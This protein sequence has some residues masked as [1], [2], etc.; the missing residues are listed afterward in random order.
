M[1][2]GELI[3]LVDDIAQ[4][5]KRAG[6]LRHAHG[7]ALVEEMH[8]LAQLDVE[9]GLTVAQRFYR[10]LHALDIAAVIGAPHIDQIAEPAAEL[11][12]VIGDVAGEIGPRPIRFFQRAIDFVAELRRAEQGLRPRLPVVRQLALWRFENAL[13]D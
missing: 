11:V 3:E 5:D 9:L 6:T 13:I 4:G 2:A 12:V 1:L 7:L 8:E 10:R